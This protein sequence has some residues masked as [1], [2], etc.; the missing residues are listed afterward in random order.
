MRILVI[1]GFIQ[2]RWWEK[3]QILIAWESFQLMESL[4]G[5][6]ERS[7]EDQV[8][9]NRLFSNQ[10]N[11]SMKKLDKSKP[12]MPHLILNA[13]SVLIFLIPKKLPFLT[14]MLLIPMNY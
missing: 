10:I 5:L 12:K 2:H 13:T 1:H 6:I 14:E 3:A 9:I 4:I 8:I 11:S 7:L